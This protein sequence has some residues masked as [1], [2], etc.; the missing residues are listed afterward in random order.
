MQ[1]TIVFSD[2]DGTLL[3]SD[4][5]ITPQT[6]RAIRHLQARRIPFVIISARSP[7]GIYPI[8]TAHGFNCP[9]VAYSGALALMKT[10]RCWPI[11]A[12]PRPWRGK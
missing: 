12:F 1:N 10:A 3:S 6:L 9:I 8:L 5:T 7:S 11:R 2:I 4:L